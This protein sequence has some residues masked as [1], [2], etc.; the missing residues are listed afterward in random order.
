V[1]PVQLDSDS[2]PVR[3]DADADARPFRGMDCTRRARSRQR[4]AHSLRRARGKKAANYFDIALGSARETLAVVDLAVALR[5]VGAVGAP[6][7][8]SRRD[9]FR[10]AL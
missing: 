7:E 10:D 8:R 1:N 2:S 9:A 3:A 4:R 5:L 6:P